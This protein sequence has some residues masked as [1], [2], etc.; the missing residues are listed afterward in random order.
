MELL[1][2]YY[3]FGESRELLSDR[4]CVTETRQR[5]SLSDSRWGRSNSPC[6]TCFPSIITLI[7]GHSSWVP[8]VGLRDSEV[9]TQEVVECVN[10]TSLAPA[11][12][13]LSCSPTQAAR[14][15]APPGSRHGH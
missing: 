3:L 6:L 5:C 15:P 14:P 2:R 1:S 7:S 11:N 9:T 4:K 8:G 12:P 13:A 10:K